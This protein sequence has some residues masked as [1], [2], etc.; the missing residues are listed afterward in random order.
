MESAPMAPLAPE[1]PTLGAAGKVLAAP[2]PAVSQALV[3]ASLPSTAAPPLHDSSAL[4]VVLERALSE[5]TQLQAD[6]LSADPCLVAGHLELA[7]GWLHSDLVVRAVLGQAIAASKREKKGATGAAAYH[8]AALKDAKAARDLCQAL[9]GE[10]QSLRDKHA[11]EVR[12][13]QEEEEEMKA[14]EQVVKSRD[15][16][17][18]EL[19]KKQAA[20]H[21]RLEELEQKM[22]MREAD[23]DAKALVLAEDHVAFADLEKRSRKALRTLYEHD[24]E[25][26]LDTD[27]DGPAQLLPLVVKALEGL[28]DGLGP[29]AEA[30]ARVLSSATLTRVLSH[31]YLRDPNT[32]LDELL[33]PVAEDHC[34]AAASAVQGQVEALLGNFRGFVSDPLSGDA[35]DPAAEGENIVAHRGAPSAGDGDIKG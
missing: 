19:G 4:A 12:R 8:E 5:M 22:G 24:L 17:L 3:M 31:L 10:L 26:P 29:M 13:H 23:L 11:E 21:N 15:A 35:A 30:E 9:E 16:E 34:E 28:V 7:S 14:W 25:E 2:G 20:E 33:E 6:L 27:E 32:R 18:A 1:V